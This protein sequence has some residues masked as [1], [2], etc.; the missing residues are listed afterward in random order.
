MEAEIQ[1][2]VKFNSI[3]S[4]FHEEPY[5]INCEL[6]IKTPSFVCALNPENILLLKYSTEPNS[7]SSLCYYQNILKLSSNFYHGEHFHQT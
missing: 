1:K 4:V 7:F 5:P 6:L 3:K 2:I